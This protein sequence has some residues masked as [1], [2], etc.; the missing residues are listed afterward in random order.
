[1]VCDSSMFVSKI[2][3]EGHTLNYKSGD[4]R[5]SF[6]RE[7]R[8]NTGQNIARVK[9][10]YSKNLI[11]ETKPSIGQKAPENISFYSI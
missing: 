9:I 6:S 5:V 4:F 3:Y 7:I 2:V 8:A 1:M 11:M 10:N